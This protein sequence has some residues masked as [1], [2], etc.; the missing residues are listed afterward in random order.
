MPGRI[1]DIAVVAG[2]A[3]RRGDKLLVLEAMKMEHTIRAP[4]AGTVAA[5]HVTVGEQVA[6]GL[7][8]ITFDA[9]EG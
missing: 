1:I 2:T 3:V 8:L 9:E 7:D 4:A 6:E 5:L